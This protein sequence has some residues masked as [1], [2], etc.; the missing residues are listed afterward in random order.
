MPPFGTGWASEMA[1]GEQDRPVARILRLLARGPAQ[2]SPSGAAGCVMLSVGEVA[3]VVDRKIVR[4]LARQG[5]VVAQ[6]T[7]IALAAP[8]SRADRSATSPAESREGG[9]QTAS[10]Q[11]ETSTGWQEVT[12]NLAESPLALLARLRMRDGSPFVSNAEVE[13]GERL[14]RDYTSGRIM[15]RL[16][17]NWEAGVARRRLSGDGLADL[18]VSAL[19]ARQRVD[20]ALSHVGPELAGVLVDVC[21]FLKGL[22][23]VERERGWP[24][25]SAKVVLKTALGA[26]CRHYCPPTP[27]KARAPYLHWGSED[28]RPE[29]S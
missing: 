19:A 2:I 29:L 14:R 11:M 26:L 9:Q 3:L 8:A 12:V 16:G 25:R 7:G 5:V 13:A 6:G 1:G 27:G 24:V 10:V 28:Y 20:R 21:C 18:T 4:Q 22:E 17:A 15:Q 23:L